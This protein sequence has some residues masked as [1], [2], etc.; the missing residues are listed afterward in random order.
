[1]LRAQTALRAS[2]TRNG[3]VRRL[4]IA[5]CL[6]SGVIATVTGGMPGWQ[7]PEA[8]PGVLLHYNPVTDERLRDPAPEDWLM[9]RRTYNGW[10]FSPLDQIDTS[11]VIDLAPAWTF[12]THADDGQPQG[13]PI[14]NGDTMFVTSAEQ[15]IALHA[16]T[17]ALRWRY[18]HPLP[19]DV[20][21]P[22]STNRGVALYEDM[23]Y[24]GT[25]DARVV[26]LKATTGE[27]VWDQ[28]IADYRRTYYITLAPL[29]VNGKIIV[30]TSGGE[31]GIRGFVIALDALTGAEI[32]KQHTIPAPG[33]PGSTT[34]SGESWRTGGGSVWV[35]GNYD[36]SHNTTYWGVG[37]GGPWTG[38]T[39]PGDNLYTNSTLALDADT[40]ELKSHHQYHW[41]GSWDWDEAN[42][43]LVVNVERGGRTIE[44]L[45]HAGRNGYLWLLEQDGGNM[46][47]LEAQPF[48]HQNVFT[49]LDPITGRPTYD[50]A[51]VPRIGA[52]VEFCPAMRGARNW[53]PEAFSPQ[54][55]L[56]Y[57][58]ATNNYCS[59]ME[60]YAVEY[61]AGHSFTGARV[62]SFRRDGTDYIGELQAWDLD[63]GRRVWTRNF[64]SPAGSVLATGGNLVFVES[65]GVLHAVD[66]LSGE[67]LWKYRAERR[68]PTGIPVSY[69]VLGVQY[70]AVQF[71][72]RADALDAGNL[73]VAFAIDCQC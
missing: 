55:G 2:S 10:G 27:V 5:V 24:V 60:G 29:A 18:E 11:N 65:G 19:S 33:E 51:R 59:A 72:A 46:R 39:R 14:V 16:R 30:G 53:R 8:V 3:W 38:D 64:P 4:V 31:Y 34:W 45:V 58:P 49:S 1:M 67:P 9:Y 23:V 63:S 20:R 43:P 69:S 47:F 50:T 28:P 37:N 54:T 52:R 68:S 44:G 26:A 57:V 61:R 71:H 13:P 15:V 32:W 42:P 35:T 36:P 40:G 62:E 25:L 21:R 17:G 73:V 66:G 6:A 12:R 22:H 41:N 56:L 48:V 7:L 70:V